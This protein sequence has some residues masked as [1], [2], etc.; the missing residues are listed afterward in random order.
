MREKICLFAGTTEGRQ[1]AELLSEAAELTVCV[2]TEYGEVLLD[3]IPDIEIRT[4][5]M[6]SDEM[7][8][9]FRERRFSRI[10]DATHPYAALV[11]ENIREAA[12]ETGI[13]VMRILR[14]CDGTVAGAEYVPSVEAARDFLMERE[15]RIFLTTGAKELSSYV[16]LDMER[17]WA[18]VLP[19]PSSLEACAAA[20]IP[21]AHIIAAQGPFSEEINLDQMKQIGARYMVTKDTG[22]AGGYRDKIAAA[23]RAGVIPVII[24]RPTRRQ[25]LSPG[26][27]VKEIEARFDLSPAPKKV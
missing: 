14:D 17:V 8:A 26:E 24:G 25:G 1:L 21:Q 16:G 12:E 11:T 9:F 20:G 10:L 23:L 3:G 22:S 2:A 19:T 18:R 4:G 27:A 15:G 5:R 13:P 6:T 7:A